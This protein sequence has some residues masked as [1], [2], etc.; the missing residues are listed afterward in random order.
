MACNHTIP[1]TLLVGARLKMKT[2]TVT[3]SPE[4]QSG[5]RIALSMLRAMPNMAWLR[6]STTSFY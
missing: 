4:Y 1:S 6:R 5:M 2:T 3:A